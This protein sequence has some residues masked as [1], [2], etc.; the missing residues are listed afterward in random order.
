MDNTQKIMWVAIGGLVTLFL[1]AIRYLFKYFAEKRL[2]RVVLDSDLSIS[3]DID[4][5]HRIGCPGIML[6][7]VCKSKRAAKLA[8]T[9]F[10]VSVTK[11]DLAAVERGFQ[12]SF[13]Q[14]D[15][16][17]LPARLHIPLIPLSKLTN[18]DGFVLERDDVARFHFPIAVPPL[19]IFLRAP[20]EDVQVTAT[21]FDGSS[22]VLQK[23]L[24]VQKMLRDVVDAYS[25]LPM[26]LNS[27]LEM[28]ITVSTDR[29]SDTGN[30]I[31]T[32]NPNAIDFSESHQ[33]IIEAKFTKD[34]MEQ[35]VSIFGEIW[36]HWSTN[37]TLEYI[38][39]PSQ[40]IDLDNPHTA[41]DATFGIGVTS[42]THN[43]SL[44]DLLVIFSI[45]GQQAAT[46][47]SIDTKDA[48]EYSVQTHIATSYTSAQA[49]AMLKQITMSPLSDA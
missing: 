16:P 40:K 18:D 9:E 23:G 14:S 3:A 17:A 25:S 10:S 20:S 35:C 4:T 39:V 2:D 24:S 33:P 26:R 42:P 41:M 13:D 5:I 44:V 47:K 37:K 32:L 6:T 21:F 45:L 28:S 48:E 43:I 11:D 22:Q 29:L 46:V 19:P 30:L 7:V 15:N 31:G 34:R 12:F 27:Q 38:V 1:A 49:S 36:N 8:K